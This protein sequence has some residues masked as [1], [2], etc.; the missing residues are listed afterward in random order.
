MLARL[1]AE[2]EISDEEI[3]KLGKITRDR[4]KQLKVAPAFAAR[5]AEH[6]ERFRDEMLRVGFADKRLRVHALNG[7]ATAL[8]T[9]LQ[10]GKYQA[11]LSVDEDGNPIMGFAAAPL[12]EFR[13]CLADIAAEMGDRNGGSAGQ[14]LTV[15]VGVAVALD[16]GEREAR[17]AAVLARL[18][19]PGD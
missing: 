9:G 12:R 6:R 18:G 17:A 8:L 14:Q 13:A 2:D 19:P 7:I 15:N 3:A 11:V 16:A 1:V 10:D 5:V 4:L